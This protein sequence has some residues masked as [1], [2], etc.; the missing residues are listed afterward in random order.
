MYCEAQGLSETITSED[1]TMSTAM[2]IRTRVGTLER[3]AMAANT[4]AMIQ[5]YNVGCVV[6]P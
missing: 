3:A 6:V 4:F 5:Y 2:K 1:K